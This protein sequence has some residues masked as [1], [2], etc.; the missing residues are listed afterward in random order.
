MARILKEQDKKE[1]LLSPVLRWFM[2][3]MVLANISG[4]MGMMLIPL[5]LDEQGASVTEIGLVFTILSIVSL[6]LQVFGG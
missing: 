1:P 4:N 5:Y 6:V 3:A 2:F